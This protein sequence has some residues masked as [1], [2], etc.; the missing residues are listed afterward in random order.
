MTNQTLDSLVL[1][2]II[3]QDWVGMDGLAQNEC[4]VDNASLASTVTMDIVSSACKETRCIMCLHT[5]HVPRAEA[6]GGVISGV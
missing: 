3:P 6:A 2:G 1:P 4:V 5:A